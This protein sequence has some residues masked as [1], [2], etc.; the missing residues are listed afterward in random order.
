[1]SRSRRPFLYDRY[2]FVSVNLLRS[3]R[4]LEERDFARL[5]IALAQ[6]RQEQRFA[7][8]AWVFLPDHWHGVIWPQ[9]PL[10][11]SVGPNGIRPWGERRSPLRL[12]RQEV[13]AVRE[14]PLLHARRGSRGPLWQHQFWDRFVGHER[15]FQE[16]MEYMH[17]NPVERGLV[18]RPAQVARTCRLGPRFFCQ[19]GTNRRPPKQVCATQCVRG[20]GR[21][22]TAEPM[23]A[24]H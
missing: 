6:M 2:F 7:L 17:L 10:L 1:M 8:T 19:L 13:G 15:E 22:R 18:K 11:M 23:Q 4:K 3:R 9:Y 5:A 21:R 16:R 12:R 24:D 20:R 14:P